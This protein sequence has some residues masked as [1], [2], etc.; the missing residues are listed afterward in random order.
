MTLIGQSY[1]W[2]TRKIQLNNTKKK[3]SICIVGSVHPCGHVLSKLAMPN[4]RLAEKA[5]AL[6][7]LAPTPGPY[8]KRKK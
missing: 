1:I 3:R 6:G 7:V 8:M 5:S 2:R 4:M